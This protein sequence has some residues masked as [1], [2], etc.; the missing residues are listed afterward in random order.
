MFYETTI[1][2]VKALLNVDNVACLVKEGD[3]TTAIFTGGAIVEIDRAI[4]D[5]Q[6]DMEEMDNGE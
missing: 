4:E 6:K 3:K 5:I 1:K 2:G